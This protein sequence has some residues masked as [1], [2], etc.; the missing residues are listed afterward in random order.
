MS[1]RTLL[2]AWMLVPAGT[3][4]AGAQRELRGGSTP[5]R[6]PVTIVLTDHVPHT[7][8]P[9]VLQ[10]RPGRSPA[11]VILLRSNA[12]PEQLADAVSALIAVRQVH[13]DQPSVAGTLRVR[14][15][16]A[17]RHTSFPWTPR[18]LADLRKA[19][20]RDVVGFGRVRSVQIWLPRAHRPRPRS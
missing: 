7:E 14:P 16:T 5:A 13:G 8:A 12:T 10:R 2:L 18:V 6:V 4:K 9:F 20:A 3:A 11:D 1:I 17:R 15:N 19:Q